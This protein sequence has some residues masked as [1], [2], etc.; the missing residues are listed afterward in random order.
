MN[1]LGRIA[2]ISLTIGVISLAIAYAFGGR[3]LAQQLRQGPLF[4]RS[5]GQSDGK[6]SERHLAW[7]GDS[8]DIALPGTVRFRAGEGSDIVIRGAPDAVAR[9]ELHGG[10]LV[11]DCSWSGAARDIEVTL[12]GQTIRRLGISGSGKVELD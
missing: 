5:C 12:P 4:A 2:A 11:L 10:H 9:V 6:S 1:Y 7:T 3:D 8:I